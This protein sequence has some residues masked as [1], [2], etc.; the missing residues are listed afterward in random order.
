MELFTQRTGSRPSIYP[1]DAFLGASLRGVWGNK[2]EWLGRTD[3]TRA[4]HWPAGAPH[5]IESDRFQ[6]KKMRSLIRL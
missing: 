6:M 2:L 4:N 5:S 1:F 3:C